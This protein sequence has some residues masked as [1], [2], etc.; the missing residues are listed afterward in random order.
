S[1]NRYEAG[2]SWPGAREIR[3]LCE[4][5]GLTSQWL[6]FGDLGMSGESK[7]E[8]ALLKALKGVLLATM[9]QQAD[10]PLSSP[11]YMQWS[12]EQLRAKRISEARKP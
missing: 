2:D 1:L 4:S 7:D 11:Q 9:A 3:L 6:L 12:A 8:Q 10:S 5:L